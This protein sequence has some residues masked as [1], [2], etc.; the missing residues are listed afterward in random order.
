MPLRVRFQFQTGNH[1]GYSIERLRDG[2]V[3][4][5]A[6]RQFSATPGTP[7]APLPEGTAPFLG[8]YWVTLDPTPAAEFSDGDYAVTVHHTAENNAVVAQLGAT[9]YR[10]DD[11][12]PLPPRVLFL[13]EAPPGFA[14]D[15]PAPPAKGS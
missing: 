11:A 13:S 6:S 15:V 4:D 10:G 12:T 14:V 7:I 5:F 2:L 3:Y 1:L 9:I 8:R